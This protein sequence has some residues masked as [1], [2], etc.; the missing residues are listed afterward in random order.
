MFRAMLVMVA[1]LSVCSAAPL[2]ADDAVPTAP[3]ILAGPEHGGGVAGTTGRDFAGDRKNRRPGERFQAALDQLDLTDDQQQAIREITA[4]FAGRMDLRRRKLAAARQQLDR[5]SERGDQTSAARAQ[6]RIETLQA[7]RPDA[8]ATFEAIDAVLTEAQRSRLRELLG[9]DGPADPGL[10]KLRQ[11][12]EQ[13][14][15]MQLPEDQHRRLN[16]RLDE[17]EAAYAEFMASHRAE[18]VSFRVEMAQAEAVGD[19]DA[20]RQAQQA[21]RRRIDE[22]PP[23][24][25]PLKLRRDVAGLLSPAQRRELEQR[26]RAAEAAVRDMTD[27]PMMDG[28]LRP[29]IAPGRD[30]TRSDQLNL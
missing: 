5:A 25:R 12:R 14:A 7:D 28:T 11:L 8:S 16:T 30:A 29:D 24:A 6:Q 2:A 17:A 23:A 10:A 20:V 26:L 19:R 27:Q 9:A 22:M 21:I 1:A 18:L 15:A 3:P 13:L 4:A